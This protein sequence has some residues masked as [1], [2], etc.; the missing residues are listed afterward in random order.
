MS[1]WENRNTRGET[2]PVLATLYTTN[3]TWP[4][5]GS[6]GLL[7]LKVHNNLMIFKYSVPTSQR[8]HCVSI[9]NT[10][11]LLFDRELMVGCRKNHTNT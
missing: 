2:C 4:S 7:D 11:N 10:S 8:T 6:P 3:L 9:T 1:T 5:L